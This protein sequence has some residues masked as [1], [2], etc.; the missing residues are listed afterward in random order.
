MGLRRDSGA[1]ILGPGG[2]LIAAAPPPASRPSVYLLTFVLFVVLPSLATAV[3]FAFI[4]SNQYVAEARF[5]VRTAQI[6]SLSDKAKS[7]LSAVTMTVGLPA[8][9]GQDAYII[10][11]YV[12]SRAILDDIGRTLDLRAIFRRPEADVLARLRDR[13]S[14][15][16]L[17]AYW[18]DM[19]SVYIDGPSGV[20][21][22]SV[23][24]FRPA[25]ALD[26]TLL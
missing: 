5:A 20:V 6:E 13:P 4:A 17:L 7:A 10:A 25:D 8:M 1:E 15:E 9:S 14:E 12:R 23:R 11:T 26:L 3:Y 18:R 16:E 19:A 2:V 22:V 24:A 21:T